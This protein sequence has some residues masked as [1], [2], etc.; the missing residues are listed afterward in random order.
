[1]A[2][3]AAFFVAPPLARFFSVFIVRLGG[4]AALAVVAVR[5]L[6]T[7][8]VLPSLATL[9]ALARRVVVRDVAVAPRLLPVVF[10]AVVAVAAAR[11]PRVVDVDAEPPEELALALDDVVVLRPVAAARVD[12]AFS[13]MLL[14]IEDPVVLVGDI[15]RAIIDLAGEGAGAGAGAAGAAGALSRRGTRELDDVGERTCDGFPCESIMPAP[16]RTFFLGFS[17]ASSSFSLS[18]PAIS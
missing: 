3:A 12:R 2:A 8:D 17:I 1:L 11:L 6:T 7:V 4:D 9:W 18:L 10:A 16:P 14:R 15:G 5:F 13:T